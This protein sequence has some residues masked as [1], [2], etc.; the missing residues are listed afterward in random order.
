MSFQKKDTDQGMSIKRFQRPWISLGAQSRLRS[1][2]C[3]AP[4]RPYLDQAIPPN[5]MTEHVGD[6]SEKLPTVQW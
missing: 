1:G 5:W 6:G 2:R 4:L 3:M